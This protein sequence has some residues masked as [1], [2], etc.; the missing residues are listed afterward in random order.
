MNECK[1]KIL[2]NKIE[3]KIKSQLWYN[4]ILQQKD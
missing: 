4:I 3:V 2:K 1:Q